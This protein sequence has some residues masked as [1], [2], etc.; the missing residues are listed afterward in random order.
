MVT[1]AFGSEVNH[2]NVRAVIHTSM[3]VSLEQ[4]VRESSIAGLDGV[5]AR[6]ILFYN[7]NDKEKM[8]TEYL[9]N[10]K[11]KQREIY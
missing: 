3:P 9:I 5:F 7:K 10:K 2:K 8:K 4:Y 1:P 6:C 11:E